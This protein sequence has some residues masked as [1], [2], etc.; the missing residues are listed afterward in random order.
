M[1]N[2]GGVPKTLPL[3][4]NAS[5]EVQKHVS[6]FRQIS[7]FLALDQLASTK[8]SVLVVG[9]GFLGSELAV[10]LASRG[11]WV[12]WGRGGWAVLL[13]WYCCSSGKMRD[14]VVTQLF[15]E[16]G[17]LGEGWG[18]KRE[19]KKVGHGESGR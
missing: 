1:H 15:P 10:A 14:H 6:V 7:D 18:P 3:F 8:Q 17:N 2:V 5:E 11:G 13:Y 4:Q 19:G 16:G 9:G 12:G